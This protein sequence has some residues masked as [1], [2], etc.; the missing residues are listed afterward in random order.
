METGVDLVHKSVTAYLDSPGYYA[1]FLDL[2]QSRV[3]TRSNDSEL[4]IPDQTGAQLLPNYPNPFHAT[5]RISF[6]LPE[7]SKVVLDIFDIHGRKVRTL[8]DRTMIAG[9]YDATWDGTNEAG[10]KVSPGVYFCI[11][12][13]GTIKLNRKIVL[14]R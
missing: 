7:K 2:T 9:A 10:L 13:T 12:R 14:M 4:N 11:L 5:T 6:E 1:V 8:V 3:V